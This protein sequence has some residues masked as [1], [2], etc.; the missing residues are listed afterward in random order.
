M[1]KRQPMPHS[2][3]G[4]HSLSRRII[5]RFC[6]FT[7]VICAIYGAFS[8]ILM[9]ALE[10]SFIEQ[11]VREEAQYLH[12]Q[13]EENGTWPA[14]RRANMALYFSAEQLPADFRDIAMEEPQRK[15]FF[16]Q[17]GRHYHLHRFSQY[18]E[19]YLVAE[20]SEQ[21]LV[22][23]MRGGVIQFLIISGLV[24]SALACAIAW[25]IGR[26][27]TRPLKQLAELVENVE[28]EKLPRQFA[29][30]FPNNEVGVLAQVL[31]QTLL[32]MSQALA[33]EKSFTRDVSHELRTPLAVI[34][35]AVELCQSRQKQN[36]GAALERIYHSAEQMEKT[37]DT[38]L[39]LARE[40]HTNRTQAEIALMPVLERAIID[41]RM[42][43]ANKPVE[44]DLDDSC[45]TRIRGDENI[46][47]VVL[48]NLLSN[49]FRFTEQGRVSLIFREGKLVISDTGPGI[50][51]AI[52]HAI[53]QAGVKSENSTGFGFGLSIVKRLC[54]HQGW[55]MEVKSQAGTSVT[56]TFHP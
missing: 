53:T 18:D 44:V 40:E 34:K 36:D 16:G 1:N 32:R 35:N 43:L 13:Y 24:V 23:P 6:I 3:T 17:Q 56:L 5:W 42:L 21:L 12:T 22:R 19:V 51:P 9:Y 50:E 33:R 10:D 37:V 49:A 55:G 8:M 2:K 45:D 47:K 26:R 41:N 28:P 48:D 14:P 27:T 15:E 52:S 29:A 54:E 31:E 7:L 20:V 38:L 39:M 11:G 46:L 30:D 4:F 25:L